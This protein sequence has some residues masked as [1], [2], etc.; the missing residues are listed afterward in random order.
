MSDYQ[1]EQEAAR[2]RQERRE[3]RAERRRRRMLK[4]ETASLLDK[5]ALAGAQEKIQ[6]T[7]EAERDEFLERDWYVRTGKAKPR[8]YRNGFAK[9]K[10]VHLGCGS[11]AV[12]MPR[13]IEDGGDFHSGLLAPYQRTSPKV[14]ETL[15]ELYLYG[16]STGDFEAALE[17]LL[18][19]G[20]AL[21]PSTI[22][23]LKE[24]W[25][26]E[27]QAW[28][29]RRLAPHYAYIWCDGV[30]IKVGRNKEKLALLVVMGV[31]VDGRK[32]LLTLIAGQR[33]SDEQWLEVLRDLRARGVRWIGLAVA[34][35]IPGFW[36]A[37]GKAF[38]A[39][40]R[41]RCWVH[42]MRNVLDK[43]PKPKQ[44]QARKSLQ[45]IYSAE[46]RAEALARIA[47]FAKSYKDYPPAVQ[48]LVENRRDLLSYFDFPKEHWVHLKTTNPVESPFSAVKSRVRRAKRMMQHWSALGLVFKLMQD[49]QTRWHRL[50]AP[51]LVA[52]VV[53]GANY[54]DG[55]QTKAA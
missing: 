36:S 2:R 9:P 31:D 12:E 27:Y 7:L 41:Q 20:A 53:A 26:E 43:L 22:S 46:T 49:Q 34:D 11:V 47:R 32:Q 19:V 37:L 8:G 3:K 51:E 50:N 33:E 28:R 24:K 45:H 6:D 44:A 14:L 42:M 13:V 17:C 15:P 55:K 48:C 18:G 16:I 10:M 30:Y 25:A 39:T 40:K 29:K 35:G 5:M 38:P 52:A 4:Q 23:R 1:K 54:R 21:S